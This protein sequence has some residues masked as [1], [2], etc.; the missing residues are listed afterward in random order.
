MHLSFSLV[1]K[2]DH[3]LV[4]SV[5]TLWSTSLLAFNRASVFILVIHVFTPNKLYQKLMCSIP[6]QYFFVFL[7]FPDGI[8]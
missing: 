7:D 3:T 8:F 4:F 6:F 5:F 2:H 1:M